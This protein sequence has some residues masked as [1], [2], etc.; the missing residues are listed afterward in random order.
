[1][2]SEQICTIDYKGDQ[3][4]WQTIISFD[5][6][7]SLYMSTNSIAMWE[8]LPNNADW[9]SFKTLI[10]REILKIRNPLRGEHYA[11]LKVV[12]LFQSVGCVRDKLLF[13]TVQQNRKSF[14]WMQD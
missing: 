8:T 7:H 1:M 12:H 3:S 6:L 10:S 13:L 2:V 5:L 4:L 9:D 11:F 14:S